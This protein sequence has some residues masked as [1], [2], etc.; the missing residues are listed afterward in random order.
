MATIRSPLRH[1]TS[2]GAAA[3]DAARRD[4]AQARETISMNDAAERARCSTQ[5]LI[6]AV[7]IGDLSDMRESGYY[8]FAADEL[9]S[10]ARARGLLLT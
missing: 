8:R 2:G 7:K 3:V 5:T 1:D 6:N 9:E 4:S 10:W